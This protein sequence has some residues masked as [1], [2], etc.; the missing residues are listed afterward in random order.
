MTNDFVADIKAA[1][2]FIWSFTRKFDI[3]IVIECKFVLANWVSKAL[4]AF[5]LF[6]YYFATASLDQFLDFVE[7]R[8]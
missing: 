4:F 3:H 8:V 1:G 2:N 6:F 5:W 7:S